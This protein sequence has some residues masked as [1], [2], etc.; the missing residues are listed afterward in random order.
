[1]TKPLWQRMLDYSDAALGAQPPKAYS[2]EDV[3]IARAHLVIVI[4]HIRDS[5]AWRN[6]PSEYRDPL[7]QTLVSEMLAANVT[8][9]DSTTDPSPSAS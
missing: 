9:G 6:T 4:R 8:D 5:D 2:A 3:L 7:L 1:M